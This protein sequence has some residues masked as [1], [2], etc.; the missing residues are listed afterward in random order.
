[1]SITTSTGERYDNEASFIAHQPSE[2]VDL[3][4][5]VAMNL[6]NV[7]NSKL[8]EDRN[9]P[10]AEAFYNL[11][12][13]LPKSNVATEGTVFKDNPIAKKAGSQNLGLLFQRM[14]EN[15]ER[16]A[17]KDIEYQRSLDD[18]VKGGGDLSTM[19]WQDEEEK[20]Q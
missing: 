5:Q 6:E 3:G 9:N 1:M 10:V 7:P 2:H 18:W 8:V 11:R 12:S 15:H 13:S 16:E 19:P 4:D 17:F 14:Y 20:T